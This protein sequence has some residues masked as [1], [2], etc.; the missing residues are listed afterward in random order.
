M[1]TQMY[2]TIRAILSSSNGTT[3]EA[4]QDIGIANPTAVIAKLRDRGQP[5]LTVRP[6][7]ANAPARYVMPFGTRDKMMRT[8]R[9]V[10]NALGAE[11]FAEYGMAFRPF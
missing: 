11:K 8:P 4:L 1:K 5:I 9:A 10:L 7:G 2:Q 3:V 6:D